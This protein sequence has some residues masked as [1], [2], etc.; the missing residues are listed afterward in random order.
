MVYREHTCVIDSVGKLAH[1]PAEQSVPLSV[2]YACYLLY[3]SDFSSV[4]TFVLLRPPL[5]N[6]EL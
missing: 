2:E 3:S 1:C 6:L 5:R 4:L